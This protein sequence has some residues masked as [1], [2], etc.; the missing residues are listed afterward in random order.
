VCFYEKCDEGLTFF[1]INTK[2]QKT[3]TSAPNMTAQMNRTVKAELLYH[4]AVLLAAVKFEHIA[5]T[6]KY[7]SS[8][9][10]SRPGDYLATHCQLCKL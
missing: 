10:K 6:A 5:I 8:D 2:K 4:M 7:S 3:D 9:T 1:L